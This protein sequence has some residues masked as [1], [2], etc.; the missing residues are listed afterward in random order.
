[1]EK[2][3]RM[4]AASLLLSATMLGG[5]TKDGQQLTVTNETNCWDMPGGASV[6]RI[7]RALAEKN[8]VNRGEIGE[9]AVVTAVKGDF[10]SPNE[11]GYVQVEVPNIYGENPSTGEKIDLGQRTCWVKGSDLK[12]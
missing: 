4:I 9:G 3:P 10:S 11:K 5:C 1:M 2:T 12:K 7:S 6:S 8:Q